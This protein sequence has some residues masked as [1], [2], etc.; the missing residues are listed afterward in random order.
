MRPQAM[1]QWYFCHIFSLLLTISW[2]YCGELQ[3]TTTN[4]QHEYT[5]TNAPVGVKS[6]ASVCIVN[7]Y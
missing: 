6:V 3:A 7:Y 2:S 1:D 4:A 5:V